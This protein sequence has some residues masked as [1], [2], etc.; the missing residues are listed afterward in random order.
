MSYFRSLFLLMVLMRLRPRYLKFVFIYS[1]AE[2]ENM[3]H[4]VS[5]ILFLFF[6]GRIKWQSQSQC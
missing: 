3:G 6:G 2:F 4:L 1:V 5:E